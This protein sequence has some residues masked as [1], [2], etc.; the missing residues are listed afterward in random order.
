MGKGLGQEPYEQ[1][2]PSDHKH[3]ERHSNPWAFM[4]I[5]IK[6]RETATAT[7]RLENI[8]KKG[9]ENL[10]HHMLTRM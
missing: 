2:N 1:G 4:E 5:Q 10:K 6:H 9:K 8:E 7:T 3:M